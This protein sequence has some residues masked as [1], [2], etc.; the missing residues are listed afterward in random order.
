MKKRKLML[1]LVS[2]FSLFA[3]FACG[4]KEN[5]TNNDFSDFDD[6]EE[7]E[8]PVYTTIELKQYESENYLF[9]DKN[10]RMYFIININV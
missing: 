9:D 10:N 4:E 5:E 6:F 3:L 8:V 2:L 1:I 7:P